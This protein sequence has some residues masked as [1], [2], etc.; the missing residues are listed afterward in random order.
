MPLIP[1]H[2]SPSD[3]ESGNSP[4]LPDD[5][6]RKTKEGSGHF[7]P[8]DAGTGV[9]Q[10]EVLVRELGTVDA[11]PTRAV[12]IREVPSLAHESGYDTMEGRSGEAESLLA[13]NYCRCHS[14]T[15]REMVNGGEQKGGGGEWPENFGEKTNSPVHR[16][17]KFSAVFG[18]TSPRSSMTMRPAGLP[19]MVMSK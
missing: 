14:W 10:H 3:E 12:V 8:E 15:V 17:R 16:A 1:T 18:T 7:S 11:L 2:A 13:C 6:K 9:L 19:P 4:N 5:K